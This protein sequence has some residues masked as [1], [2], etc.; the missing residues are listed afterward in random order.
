MNLFLNALCL[1]ISL[2]SY[3]DLFSIKHKKKGWFLR[4]DDKAMLKRGK[5]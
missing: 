4:K 3:V 2:V 5:E 1:K